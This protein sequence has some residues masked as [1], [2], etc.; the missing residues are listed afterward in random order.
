M[1]TINFKEEDKHPLEANYK[2]VCIQ[3]V[4]QR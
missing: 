3:N 4:G 1:Q 2:M